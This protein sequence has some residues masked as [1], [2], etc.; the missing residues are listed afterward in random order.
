MTFTVLVDPEAQVG[1]LR[2]YECLLERAECVEDLDT[3]DRA[4][5]AIEVAIASL[6]K[7]LFL[8]RRVAEGR[9]TPFAANSSFRS[10]LQ[11]MS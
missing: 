2:L 6:S 11:G 7:A 1:L 10:E 9:A 3:A 5:Q 8:F 4:L